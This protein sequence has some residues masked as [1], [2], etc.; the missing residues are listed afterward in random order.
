M[1]EIDELKKELKIVNINYATLRMQLEQKDNLLKEIKE[2][3][4][5][6]HTNCDEWLDKLDRDDMRCTIEQY[7]DL[8]NSIRDKLKDVK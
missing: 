3:I 7:C 8:I 2:I 6:E 4:E 1:T 5:S